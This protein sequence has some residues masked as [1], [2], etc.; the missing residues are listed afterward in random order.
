MFTRITFIPHRIILHPWEQEFDASTSRKP[1]VLQYLPRRTRASRHSGFLSICFH[2][3][4]KIVVFPSK[5]QNQFSRRSHNSYISTKTLK[6][7]FST[8]TTN[9]SFPVKIT[10]HVFQPNLQNRVLLSKSI[11]FFVFPPTIAKIIKLCF[12]VKI[13]NLGVSRRHYNILLSR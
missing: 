10:N 11:F 1:S 13:T 9:F 5:P 12:P 2:Q 8:Q 3:N 7:C 4:H 6:S